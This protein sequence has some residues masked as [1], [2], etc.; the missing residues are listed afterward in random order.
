MPLIQPSLIS[1]SYITFVKTQ[2]LILI[3]SINLIPGFIW[4]SLN[5]PQMS[6]C[7]SRILFRI[8]LS[9]PL[10]LGTSRALKIKCINYEKEWVLHLTLETLQP[11]C[12]AEFSRHCPPSFRSMLGI[13]KRR[14][15]FSISG[16]MPPTPGSAR[17]R[18]LPRPRCWPCLQAVWSVCGAQPQEKCRGSNTCPASKKKHLPVGSQ[19]RNQDT[20]LLGSARAPSVW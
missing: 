5:I 18:W 2:K 17:Q 15:W 14:S 11:W 10:T 7:Y 12:P 20:W 4:I 13:W 1:T 6:F 3:T 16:E 8:P 19:S 9:D